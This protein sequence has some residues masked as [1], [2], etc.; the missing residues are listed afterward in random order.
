MPPLLLLLGDALKTLVKILSSLLLLMMLPAQAATDLSIYRAYGS[1]KNQSDTERNI[2]ASLF[3]GEVIVR[4]SGRRDAM[5]NPVIQRSIPKAS[6]YLFSFSYT[7]NKTEIIEG[8]PQ[9]RL[10]IQL[11]FSPQA[12][13]QLL[14]EAQLP[15]WP[16]PRPQIL[17]WPVFQ[18]GNGL[19]RVLD[20]ELLQEMKRQAYLRGISIQLPDLDLEDNL[21]LPVDDLWQLDLDRIRAASARYKT[22]FVAVVRF[23]PQSLGD[24]PLPKLEQDLLME[25]GESSEEFSSSSVTSSS[26]LPDSLSTETSSEPVVQGPWVIEWQLLDQTDFYKQERV[27]SLAPAFGT[28][29]QDIAD[30]LSNRYAIALGLVPITSCYLQIGSVKDFSAMK[31]SQAYLQSLA[32]VQ[33][34]E[35]LKVNQDGLLARLTI[36][37]DAR[38][39]ESTLSLGQKLRPEFTPVVEQT[40]SSVASEIDNGLTTEESQITSIAEPEIIVPACTADQPLRYL[41]QE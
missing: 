2:A 10:G 20:E 6:S 4:V 41:W 40:T 25:P 17:L 22:D 3:L 34:V 36:E 19:Q 26:V 32:L 15:L 8:K 35:L 33:K 28:F 27:D 18:D 16:S 9:V 14:R 37:G 12:I 13:N 38:L 39:L 1:V 29:A 24:L 31:Q 7:G 11:D 30:K 21:A 5:L 23:Q